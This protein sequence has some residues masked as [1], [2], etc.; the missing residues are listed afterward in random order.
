MYQEFSNDKYNVM[1]E[2]Q[3]ST[4]LSTLSQIKDKDLHV[5]YR[6]TKTLLIEISEKDCVIYNGENAIILNNAKQHIH[7]NTIIKFDFSLKIPKIHLYIIEYQANPMHSLFGVFKKAEVYFD[8]LNAKTQMQK[9]L[10]LK[11]SYKAFKSFQAT[12]FSKQNPWLCPYETGPQ[13]TQSY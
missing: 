7:K 9:E 12:V 1:T 6:Q 3:T 5:Y 11:T 10:K 4:K 8:I 2:E 13:K